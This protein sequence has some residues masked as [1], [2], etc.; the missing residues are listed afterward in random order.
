MNQL[1]LLAV[2]SLIFLSLYNLSK[3]EVAIKNVKKILVYKK[4]INF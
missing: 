3:S 1:K 4:L 2:Y